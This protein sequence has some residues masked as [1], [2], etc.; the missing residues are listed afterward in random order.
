MGALRDDLR[1]GNALGKIRCLAIYI[2]NL[3]DFLYTACDY[4]GLE[5]L[6]VV[7]EV[8]HW[9]DWLVRHG[10][11]PKERMKFELVDRYYHLPSF[12]MSHSKNLES[13]RQY[14]QEVVARGPGK[15]TPR[16][17]FVRDVQRE[18]MVWKR[19]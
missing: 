13:F 15:V 7:V 16:V 14:V 11:V 8:V 6:F 10:T 3:R 12:L 18:P 1:R 5:L 4:E 2:S 9:T 19:E 17:E